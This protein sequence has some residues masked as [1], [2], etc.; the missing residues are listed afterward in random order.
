MGAGSFRTTLRACVRQGNF[1]TRHTQPLACAPCRG[2]DQNP[3]SAAPLQPFSSS[4]S[5]HYSHTLIRG[6]L[7]RTQH[8]GRDMADA[9]WRTQHGGA[10]WRTQ[11]GGSNMAAVTWRGCRRAWEQQWRARPCRP[12]QRGGGRCSREPG[13]AHPATVLPGW[14]SEVHRGVHAVAPPPAAPHPPA[15]WRLRW[16][17]HALVSFLSR[18]PGGPPPPTPVLPRPH[19]HRQAT[20]SQTGQQQ[21][22]DIHGSSGPRL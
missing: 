10:T 7:W 2:T 4:L 16:G 18:E 8:G 9:T 22:T 1:P 6:R 13:G 14:P 20:L 11:H 19:S 15:T 21:P 17:L 3:S 5:R 12:A